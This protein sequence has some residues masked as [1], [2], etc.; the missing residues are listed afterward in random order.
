MS[1]DKPALSPKKP[2]HGELVEPY[3]RDLIGIPFV[4]NGRDP[5]TGLDCWGL[6]RVAARRFGYD[7]PDFDQAIYEALEINE[8]FILQTAR[9]GHDFVMSPGVERGQWQQLPEPIPGCIVAMAIDPDLPDVIVHLGVC[10]GGGRALHTI[11][12]HNSSLIRLDDNF[13]YR[14]IRGYYQWGKRC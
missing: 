7:I 1:P 4:Q 10:I 14:K 5:K 11:K 9:G 13:W 8:K 12:K 6:C 2:A 3:L